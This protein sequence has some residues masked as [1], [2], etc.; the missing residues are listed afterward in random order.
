MQMVPE[1]YE[2]TRT[3]YRTEYVNERYTA[4]RTECVPEGRTCTKTIY[5]KGPEWRDQVCTSYKCV[6]TM[7]CRT[8]YKKVTVCKTVT[9]VTRK[10]VDKG[11]YECQQVPC[12]PG[13]FA[14][15][16]KCCGC[17]D[18]C[19]PCPPMKTKKVWVPCPVWIETPC[20]KVVKC[21][22][23]VPC[24]ENVCV[25]KMVPVQTTVRVCT[26]RC[27]PRCVTSTYTVNVSRCVPYEA[28]RCV[29]KC[30]PVCEKVTCCRM[31]CRPVVKE[32]CCTPCCTPCCPKSCCH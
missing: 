13:L 23:C 14:R 19:E 1:Q 24:T 22:E 25:N 6:P 12:K 9:T 4:Y 18:C 2:T 21:T 3:V 16:K 8:T 17:D 7:E 10:C 31:V 29:A 27:V 30:V 32:V 5:E 15:A 20:T 26:Y 28:T 11:H